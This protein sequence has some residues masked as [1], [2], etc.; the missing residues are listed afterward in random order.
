MPQYTNSRIAITNT[1]NSANIGINIAIVIPHQTA[2]FIATP[3]H[4]TRHIAVAN[5]STG[6]VSKVNPGQTPYI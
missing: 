1:G 2:Y 6:T 5:A 4:I 3:R